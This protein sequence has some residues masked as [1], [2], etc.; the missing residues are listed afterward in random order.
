MFLY[1]CAWFA[2]GLTPWW[3]NI[4][5]LLLLILVTR[6][7]RRHPERRKSTYTF[8]G[9]GRDWG[10]DRFCKMDAITRR[11]NKL[12]P[13]DNARDTIWIRVRDCRWLSRCKRE[14]RL[15]SRM[16]SFFKQTTACTD[17]RT[18]MASRREIGRKRPRRDGQSE[19]CWRLYKTCVARSIVR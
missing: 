13:K 19:S 16:E 14:A 10:A 7:E 15:R 5:Y 2:G 12:A 1:L 6:T 3:S 18:S 8:G 17:G 9:E 11:V 4:A